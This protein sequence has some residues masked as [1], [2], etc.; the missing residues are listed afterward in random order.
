MSS[1]FASR[2]F[3]VSDY[4]VI[5][6]GAQKNVGPSG[7]TFVIIRKSLLKEELIK[8][9]KH[10]VPLM[11]DYKLQ[12]D[13]NSLYNTPPTFTIYVCDLVLKYLLE[14]YVSLEALEKANSLK[15]EKLYEYFEKHSDFYFLPVRRE[16]R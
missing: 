7:V 2:R 11:L 9:R 5:I 13:N 8:K 16:F 15:A 6:A 1:N 10:H 12:S 4:D 3:N 14:T